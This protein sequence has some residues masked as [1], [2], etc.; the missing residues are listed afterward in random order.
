MED[1]YQV[2]YG[3]PPKHTR[4]KKGQSGNAKGRPKKSKNM[5]TLLLRELDRTISVKESGR[6][7]KL[8]KREALVVRW[9]NGAMAGDVR[10]AQF[11][12]KLASDLPDDF[13]PTA[14]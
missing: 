7:R 11:V 2:G 14:D 4:F 10:L 12:M 9:V 8:T 3:R 6:D 5:E 13:I 1:D